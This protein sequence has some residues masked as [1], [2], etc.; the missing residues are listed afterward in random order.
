MLLTPAS[1]PGLNS[2]VATG[3]RM[4]PSDLAEHL[5][6]LP[7]NGSPCHRLLDG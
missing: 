4:F 2:Q 1:V 6:E 5:I 3:A 7:E